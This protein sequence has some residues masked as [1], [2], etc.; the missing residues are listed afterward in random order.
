MSVQFRAEFTNA[1]NHPWLS[2]DAGA[3]GT[4]E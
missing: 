4:A 2:G 1:F 3:S